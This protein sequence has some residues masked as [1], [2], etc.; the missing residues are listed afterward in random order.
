MRPKISYTPPLLHF[1]LVSYSCDV[2]CWLQHILLATAMVPCRC[3]AK[4][5][6]IFTL[7]VVA[8][9]AGSCC[10]SWATRSVRPFLAAVRS[11][12]TTGDSL[13][14]ACCCTSCGI[15]PPRDRLSPPLEL[16]GSSISFCS[17]VGGCVSTRGGPLVS[18]G[19]WALLKRPRLWVVYKS[20]ASN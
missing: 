6:S 3:S 11:S 1:C 4:A 7:S 17:T 9:L 20:H 2:N 5:Y 15:R 8:A 19:E 18:R 10:S 12:L 14:L 16:L 13:C